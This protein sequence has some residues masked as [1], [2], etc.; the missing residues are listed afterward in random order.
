MTDKTQTVARLLRKGVCHDCEAKPGEYHDMGCDV[1]RCPDCGG[2]L[3]ACQ[4]DE[5]RETFDEGERLIWTGVWPGTEECI[6]YG[7]FNKWVVTGTREFRGHT[8]ET[9]DWIPCDIDDPDASADLCELSEKATWD[10]NKRKYV[11]NK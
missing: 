2:Q 5:P 3:I 6:E 1:E 10:S 8:L 11:L 7:F 4:C 9:G